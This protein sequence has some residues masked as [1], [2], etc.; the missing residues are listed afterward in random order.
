MRISEFAKGDDVLVYED[1]RRVADIVRRCEPLARPRRVVEIGLDAPEH[2]YIANNVI[3]HNVKRE[4]S[5]L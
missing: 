1:G 5:A 3:A 2:T 4:E